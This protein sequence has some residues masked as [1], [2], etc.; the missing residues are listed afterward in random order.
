[1]SQYQI[2]N[3]AL[4][5]EVAAEAALSPRL[6]KNRNF[7][8]DNADLCHRLINALQPGTYVQPHCHAEVGKDESMVALSGQFGC[9]IFD[10]NGK[11]ISTCVLAAGTENMGIN[12]PTG[13]F[14]SLVALAPDSVFFETK[15]GP[16]VPVK[17]HERA[18]W[19]PMEGDPACAQYLA[20]MLSHF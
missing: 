14:H 17:D 18:S 19:A 1:M 16:W 9:L 12:I 3:R 4:L 8:T 5:A 20:F 7:H 13:V 10:N 6:R 15:Q 11:V 2:I